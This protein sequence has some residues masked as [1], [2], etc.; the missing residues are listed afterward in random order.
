MKYVV[1]KTLKNARKDIMYII[2]KQ[3]INK[4]FYRM[5]FIF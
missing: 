4:S 1:S 3:Q 5:I 2:K